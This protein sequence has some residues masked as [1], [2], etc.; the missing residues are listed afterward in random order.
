MKIAL[1]LVSLLALLA[2]CSDDD[3]SSAPA[4]AEEFAASSRSAAA[5]ID[6]A[7]LA[8]RLATLAG[9]EMDGRD[10]LTDGSARARAWLEEQ[11]IAAGIEPLGA[12]GFEQPFEQ[13]VNLIGVIPGKDPSLAGEYVVVS[14]HYDHLGVVGAPRSQCRAS[15]RAPGDTVCNGAADNAAGSVATLAVANALANSEHGTRRSIL[16]AFWDAE[17]DGL[18]GSRYFADEQPLVPLEQ[19]VAMYSVDNVGGYII[20]GV[21]DSFAIGTEY[22]TGLRERVKAI[23]EETG[24]TQWPVSSFFVGSDTGGRSDHLP[25]RLHGVPIIFFGS[26]SPP[27]YH[28]PADDLDVVSLEKLAQITRHVTLMTA[29]VANADERPAFV[30]EPVPQ[31]DDARALLALGLVVREDPSALGITDPLLI[32]IL[33]GWITRLEQFIAN[34]PQTDAAWRGYENYVKSI[35]DIV[36]D[37]IGGEALSDEEHSH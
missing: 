17:E 35:L 25:F 21:E 34:P 16:I 37:V 5:A 28:T 7:W 31:I 18:L 3:S 22:A 8:P 2:A 1:P 27:E 32:N 36:Y 24:F 12:D 13:G 23:N 4:S 11:M 33:E 9:D 20:K 14:G 19:I 30:A 29:D 15:S 26:G 10:N 6:E